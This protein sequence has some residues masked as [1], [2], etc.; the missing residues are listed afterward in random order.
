MIRIGRTGGTL[1]SLSAPSRIRVDLTRTGAGAKRS[2]AGRLLPAACRTVR[3]LTVKW[4]LAT[5][6]DVNTVLE[7]AEEG[8]VY[9]EYADPITGTTRTDA[10]FVTECAVEKTRADRSDM[11]LRAEEI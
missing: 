3:I 4:T 1:R 9:M 10:F 6:T 5:E 2:A 11:T 7:L 8:S